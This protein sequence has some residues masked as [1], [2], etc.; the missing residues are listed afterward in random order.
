MGSKYLKGVN[1][2]IISSFDEEI[3]RNCLI[4]AELNVENDGEVNETR[5]IFSLRL[6]GCNPS[7]GR[8]ESTC[9]QQ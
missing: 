9:F 2:P 6:T 3:Q 7:A 5:V 1:F 4:F 8:T